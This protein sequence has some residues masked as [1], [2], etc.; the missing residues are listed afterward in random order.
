[1]TTNCTSRRR[2]VLPLAPGEGGRNLRS[3]FFASIPLTFIPLTHQSF[4]AFCASSWPFPITQSHHHL[5]DPHIT[6]R[7]R[8]RR[9]QTS[10]RARRFQ[11]LRQKL[12]LFPQ[13]HFCLRIHF[14]RG[15]SHLAARPAIHRRIQHEDAHPNRRHPQPYPPPWQNCLRPK[16]LQH[17]RAAQT[18]TPLRLRLRHRLPRA[19]RQILRPNCF[20][21]FLGVAVLF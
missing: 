1:M 18:R 5:F 7:P 8:Y 15:A 20:Q 2:F 11:Q 16:S 12:T 9:L 19:C 13:H 6:P 14:S 10:R 17:R 4:C 21:A 3:P